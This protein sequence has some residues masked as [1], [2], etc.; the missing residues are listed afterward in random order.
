MTTSFVVRRVTAI[1]LAPL[2]AVALTSAVA[3]ESFG[4]SD[5]LGLGVF[6]VAIAVGTVTMISCHKMRD[7]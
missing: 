2:L 7:L 4:W 5:R 3:D 6:L 1:F